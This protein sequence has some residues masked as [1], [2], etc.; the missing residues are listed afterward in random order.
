MDS[1][2]KPYRLGR[3]LVMFSKAPFYFSGW[4]RQ[5]GVALWKRRIPI[6]T[7]YSQR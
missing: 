7:H 2:C 5:L 3:Y 4:L 6:N 1:W